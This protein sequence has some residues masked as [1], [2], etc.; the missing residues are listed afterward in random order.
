VLGKIRGV[1]QTA[2]SGSLSGL[3]LGVRMLLGKPCDLPLRSELSSLDRVE[4]KVCSSWRMVL[5]Q[6]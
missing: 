3:D 4:R 6:V 5:S 1:R 2:V